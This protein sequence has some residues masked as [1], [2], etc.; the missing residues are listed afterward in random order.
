MQ[1][2]IPYMHT[3]CLNDHESVAKYHINKVTAV[4]I[5]PIVPSLNAWVKTADPNILTTAQLN[6]R[7]HDQ[8]IISCDISYQ[9]S[10]R[11]SVDK[12]TQTHRFVDGPANVEAVVIV[13]QRREG[14]VQKS[15]LFLTTSEKDC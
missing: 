6:G 13:E 12:A 9:R 7:T 1:K 3:K 4:Q 14:K 10:Y 2:C 11:D 5:T 8:L 15:L